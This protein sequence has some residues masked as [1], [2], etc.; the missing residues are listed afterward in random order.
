MTSEQLTQLERLLAVLSLGLTAALK[1]QVITI[2]EAEQLLYSPFTITKLRE[3]GACQEIVELIYAGTE[4]EDLD[5]LLPN[6]L[7]GSLTQM[8]RQA[9]SLLA[10]L[11]PRHAPLET[12]LHEYLR[13][14]RE[15]PTQLRGTL[16]GK[17]EN[18]EPFL[19]DYQVSLTPNCP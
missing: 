4:L 7:T 19:G 16:A 1:H 18:Y 10:T 14:R 8:E 13:P 3:L 5:S 9:R 2:E 15:L 6:E 11:E 12:W 17:A